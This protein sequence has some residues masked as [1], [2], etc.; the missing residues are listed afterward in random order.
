MKAVKRECRVHDRIFLAGFSAGAQ[1]VQ[2]YAF[3]YPKSVSGVAVLSS[4]NYYEPSSDASDI[5]FLVVIGDQDNPTG[6]KR[7]GVFSEMLKQAGF[8]IDLHILAGV[9]H[10]IT[11]QAKEPTIGFY[12]RISRP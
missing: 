8:S 12:R 5:P 10:E 9:K 11:S 6:V 3:A 4:G 2:G 7:A 1:F